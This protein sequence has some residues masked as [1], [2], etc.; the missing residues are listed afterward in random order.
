MADE[1]K[2]DNV[3]PLVPKKPTAAKGDVGD[4]GFAITAEM[5]LSKFE[6]RYAGKLRFVPAWGFWL[7]WTGKVWS[8]DY[9]AVNKVVTL[10]AELGKERKNKDRTKIDSH[11]MISGTE[12][13]ARSSPVFS[14]AVERFDAD[15][16]L[17]NT[18]GGVVELQ[19]GN[20][21][22]G[23]PED[24]CTKLTAAAPDFDA[25]APL[26]DKFIKTVTG[27]DDA[28]AEYLLRVLGYCL[29]GE[30]SEQCLFFLF[31]TGA[32]G[33][34]V[35]LNTAQHILGDYAATAA[36][37]TFAHTVHEKHAQDLASLRG[38]RLV[39]ASETE[40]SKGW[41]EAKVK[42]LTGGDK[43]RA[44]F[45]RQ[46]SFEYR[47][48]FKLLIAGNHKPK[49]RSVDEAIQRRQQIIPFAITIEKRDTALTAKLRAEAGPILA[50]MVRGCLA[51]Q[52]ERLNPPEA[53]LAAV[54]DYLEE[55]D[56]LGQWLDECCTL[57]P[58]AF[59]STEDLFGSWKIWAENHGEPLG[60]QAGLTRR[61]KN[62]PGLRYTKKP[63][64]GFNGISTHAT[65]KDA[66]DQI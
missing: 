17:L 10:L 33:K 6:E 34:S 12:R 61:L 26:W 47:P 51:W 55:E 46:D 37:E 29:T 50:A 36:M 62:R 11:H 16:W 40:E 64:R 54:K 7:E 49:L 14:A 35:F 9:C 65:L 25:P 53:V 24:Y 8:R 57:S 19:T 3:I 45:M 38:A 32:N 41:N 5:M 42:Q 66:D 21:R 4:P 48:A 30:T 31:G 13:L 18:P 63:R 1:E 52:A 22:P 28:L 60:K 58:G 56:I 39:L 27:G 20:L 43:I 23:R 2:P 15:P 44:N 59:A